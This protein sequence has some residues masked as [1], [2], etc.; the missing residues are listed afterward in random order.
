MIGRESFIEKLKRGEIFDVV[1]VGGGITGSGVLRRLSMAGLKAVLLEQ[2]DFAWG[3]SSRSG[4]L[5]HGGLRYIKQGQIFLTCHSVRER[6]KLLKRYR[7]LILPLRFAIPLEKDA[8][9]KK[10]VYRLGLSLYDLF[11][12][13]NSVTFE[14]RSEL[15]NDF[16][17]INDS[18]FGA[19]TFYDAVTDDA[20]LTLQ[21][22]FE[23]L[24]YG[25]KAVNYAKVCQ[26]KRSKKYYEVVFK[27]EISGEHI[28][29]PSNSVVFAT[30]AWID[31]FNDSLSIR[32]L[33]GS[34]LIL[35]FEKIPVRYA[36]ALFH[37]E[38]NRPLYLMPWKGHVL[39]GTTD[40]D[41][42]GSLD[43]EVEISREE[44]RYL[45]RA[46]NYWFYRGKIGEKDVISTF[47]GVRG[48]INTHK[49]D[50]S[51]ETRDYILKIKERMVFV[52]GG[53]LTTFDYISKKV[54]RKVF[55]ILDKNP[56]TVDFGRFGYL[57]KKIEGFIGMFDQLFWKTISDHDFV[58]ILRGSFVVHLD[59]LA[60][61]RSRLGLTEIDGGLKRLEEKKGLI[62]VALGWN[63]KTYRAE[64]DRYKNILGYYR[65]NG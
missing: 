31:E 42:K 9:F 41:Y 23:A 40:I 45:L 55:G 6:E 22:M 20:Q 43:G 27:D 46:L 59:D 3:T 33:K 29:I 49:K 2:K 34:H 47:S 17:Y 57:A 11:A 32:K 65:L 25:A 14:D 26:I 36:C 60:L 4:K 13:K 7:H 39:F 5:I 61:R 50:P 54:S 1:V 12:L 24:E 64:L 48:V 30:G 21:I 52:A 37:P 62:M 56:A 16:K 19:Y 51:K 28:V 38:D 35:P 53:K 15:I 44:L 63:E 18:L 8:F 58:K 10:I